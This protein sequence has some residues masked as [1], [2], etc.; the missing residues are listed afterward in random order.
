MDEETMATS[1]TQTFK[2]NRKMKTNT[3]TNVCYHIND[4]RMGI[5]EAEIISRQP[6]EKFAH[7]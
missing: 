5:M 2:T 4:A 3:S 1:G 6:E 7:I